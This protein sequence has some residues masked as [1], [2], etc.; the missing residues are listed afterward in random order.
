MTPLG[1]QWRVFLKATVKMLAGAAVSPRLAREVI[2]VQTRS[3]DS[4]QVSGLHWPVAKTSVFCHVAFSKGL[5]QN[6]VTGYRLRERERKRKERE[7]R[8]EGGVE[9]RE[10]KERECPRWKPQSFF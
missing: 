5:I 7:G 6:M 3:G 4:W 9:R 2:C 1:A 10:N 8:E